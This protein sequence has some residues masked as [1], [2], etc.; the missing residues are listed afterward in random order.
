MDS[1]SDKS[2]V[3][4]NLGDD[5]YKK[6]SL[7]KKSKITLIL[8]MLIISLCCIFF[9]LEAIIDST[10]E[11]IEMKIYFTNNNKKL[12]DSKFFQTFVDIFTKIL[13]T[14][15]AIMIYISLIYL[16]IH[17]FIGLKLILV[18]TISQ[19]IIIILQIIYQ[20][21][22]PFWDIEQPEIV[23]RNSYP[24]PSLHF[25]YCSFFYL[26][27]FISFNMFKKK[28][29][30][31]KKKN[32]IL[33]VYIVMIAFYYF[34]FIKSY[35]LYHHQIVYTIILSLVAIVILIDYDANIYN[36]IFNSLK[37]LYNTR[38]Y[39][40][41]I[42][43]FVLGLFCFGL[44]GLFFVE[45]NND[46]SKIKENLEKNIKCTEADKENF[47]IKEGI[48]DAAFLSALVG[49]FWGASYTVE[50]NIGKWWS[51]RSK[52]RIIIKIICTLIVNAAFIIIKVLMENIKIKFELYLVL[53][54]FLCFF[55]SYCIFG[56]IPLFF[57]K[58]NYNEASIS[59]SYEKINIKLTNEN[60]VQLFRKS[61]FINEN[62]G[63][64]DVF[65]VID[66]VEKED[67]KIKEIKDK[68]DESLKKKESLYGDKTLSAINNDSSSS[69]NIEERKEDDQNIIN[70]LGSTIIKNMVEKNEDEGDYE[71]VFDNDKYNKNAENIN[72]L[73]EDL[74]NNNDN[75]EE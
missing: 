25:F 3:I 45:I 48:L 42:F 47:G 74:I 46:E 68:E 65:V 39:K 4:M 41:K 50:K 55:E 75:E 13:G 35:F 32:I 71:F 12:I 51:L 66:K 62:T 9:P 44:L 63:K 30:S 60:D 73:K 59:K 26:Y 10:L 15:E 7:T 17:P 37:N 61:I 52:K 6:L 40:M 67:H 11:D 23:C 58:I 70:E 16:I 36:F 38:V 18:S 64:K 34:I 57:Q 28:K 72:K 20:A 8:R 22:R 43:Y 33:L 5:F 1:T 56:L 53:K 31:P 24:N 29:F 2:K 21:H 19:F 14:N 27:L 49:A 54:L 69:E